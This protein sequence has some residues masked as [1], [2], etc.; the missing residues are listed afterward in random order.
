MMRSGIFD[1]RRATGLVANCLVDTFDYQSRWPRHENG[2]FDCTLTGMVSFGKGPL[3][4]LIIPRGAPAC[5]LRS[6]F[7]RLKSSLFR[8]KHPK[9]LLVK[10]SCS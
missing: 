1:E 8:Q 9:L 6:G 7:E 4:F 2:F 10:V 3:K 5:G